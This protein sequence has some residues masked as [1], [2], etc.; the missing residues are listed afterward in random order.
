M[1][2]GNAFYIPKAGDPRC[3]VKAPKKYSLPY[4]PAMNRLWHVPT[5]NLGPL[6]RTQHDFSNQVHNQRWA[7]IRDKTVSLNVEG[8]TSMRNFESKFE[9]VR[10]LVR[11]SRVMQRG[12][13][14][15]PVMLDM[16]AGIASTAAAMADE[17]GA[18]GAMNVL[19][20]VPVDTYLRLGIIIADRVLPA[21]LFRYN[22]NQVPLAQGGFDLVHCRWCWLHNYGYDTWLEE[23]D[24]LLRPGGAF[25]F[26][27][28]PIKDNKIL[29]M[30]KWNE[31]LSKRD[32]SC[33]RK[34]R[35]MQ[36]CIKAGNPACTPPID[37]TSI[38]PSLSVQAARTFDLLRKNSESL[39]S[40]DRVL[41]VSCTSAA[42]CSVVEREAR[43]PVV[44]H[45]FADDV[46]GREGLKTIMRSGGVG[47]L[48]NWTDP[49]PF[50][51]RMFDIVMIFCESEAQ[52]TES[53]LVEM[54]RVLRPKGFLVSSTRICGHML[55]ISGMLKEAMFESLKLKKHDSKLLIAR[56]LDVS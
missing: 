44:L 20:F 15:R 11:Y 46:R 10:L 21:F 47:I 22:G 39:I 24:R 38:S 55:K 3:F 2:S 51:P 33:E 19:S 7:E 4:E 41:M 12:C 35:I 6:D 29:D 26:T 49:G 32:W 50:Y 18:R 17:R 48:H 52:I 14:T 54:H 37:L 28:T 27:F 53:L 45:T 25:I 30:A 56:R 1:C 42:S 36:I 13:S 8:G 23:E 40:T 16:G 43:K 5:A 9:Y 34:N 31:S